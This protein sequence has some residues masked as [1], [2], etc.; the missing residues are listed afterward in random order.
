MKP[1][2][3]AQ[4]QEQGELYERRLSTLLDPS[5]PLKVLAEAIDWEFFER[6]FG[7]LYVERKGRPGLPMRLL[8]GLHYLKHLY[9]VSDESA[10]A[11]FVENPYWQYFCGEEF[12]VH[13]LPCDPTSLVK[14]RKRIGPGGMERLLQET[15]AAAQRRQALKPSE[16]R[17]V[18]VDTTV[19]EKAIAFPTDARLYHKARCV[20][21]REAQR[22][23]I[24]LRQ[25]Y[26][27]VGKRAL[28]KQGRYA[29]AQQLRRA[30]KETKKLRTYLG[31]VIRDIQ[32]KAAASGLELDQQ[33]SQYL[34]RASRIYRQQRSDNHK[35]YSMQAPEVECISK[36]KEHKKYEF[37]CKVS[38]VTTSKRSWVVGIA[39]LH[40]NPYDGHTLKAACAQ[41]EKIAGV[42]PEEI[43]VDKGYRGAQHH[44]E[45]VAVYI[46]GRK[47]SGTLKRLLRR[48]SAIE[49]VIGHLKH[50]HRMTR[51]FLHGADGDRINALLVGCGFNLRKLTRVFFWLIFGWADPTLEIELALPA[52]A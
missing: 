48:R 45:N 25:S 12:F 40:G 39:A 47:L 27:R 51:N 2:K 13:E 15:I 8:V 43:F 4:G 49:P 24:D 34:E 38:V 18:N 20:L 9:D 46:S 6:E 29:H 3:S 44:P 14:W 17:R 50:D 28:Q 36:G 52:A 19:Q 1:A 33:L 21:V 16:I 5:H 30:R 37:G 23:G 22:V 10:V 42:K 41:V 7:S 11:G 32:R 31:R 26:R 35:L